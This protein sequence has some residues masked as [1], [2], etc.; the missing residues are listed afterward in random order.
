MNNANGQL[1]C[2]K[3][4]GQAGVEEGDGEGT[5]VR[6]I[7]HL[8]DAPSWGFASCPRVPGAT[9]TRAAARE[10]VTLPRRLLI[11]HQ[12]ATNLSLRPEP[13]QT[14]KAAQLTRPGSALSVT[15]TPARTCRSESRRSSSAKILRAFRGGFCRIFLPSLEDLFQLALYDKDARRRPACPTPLTA[16][17]GCYSPYNALLKVPAPPRGIWPNTGVARNTFPW[18]PESVTAPPCTV[19]GLRVIRLYALAAER[20]PLVG[21]RG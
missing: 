5:A 7:A 20:P 21:R 13:C 11:H 3:M 10:P 16:E 17:F 8:S 12:R 19:S 15:S 9:F 4:T 6:P 18:A 2:V 1:L 14:E